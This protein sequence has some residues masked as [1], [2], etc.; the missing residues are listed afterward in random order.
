[1]GQDPSAA[2]AP[3]GLPLRREP[4]ARSLEAER[5]ELLREGVAMALYVGLSLL[6]VML[7]Q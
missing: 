6:D 5:A 4:E 2:T 7:V 3:G 1:V